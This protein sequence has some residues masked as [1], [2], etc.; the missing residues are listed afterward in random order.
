MWKC[1]LAIE[2]GVFPSLIDEAPARDVDLLAR[3]YEEEP[4][5]ALRDNLHAAIIAREVQRPQLRKGAKIK[6]EQF[7]VL[8]PHR[9]ESF[10]ARA[11]ASL[12]SALKAIAVPRR[13]DKAKKRAK[14]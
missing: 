1:R 12:V 4:F 5:G 6:L 11:V 14:Q 3:Y 2:L 8:A 9:R 13:K 10:G 7:L